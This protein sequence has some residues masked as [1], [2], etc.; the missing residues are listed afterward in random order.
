MPSAAAAAPVTTP[1]ARR[2][3][4]GTSTRTPRS[5]TETPSGRRYVNTVWTGS[6]SATLTRQRGMRPY[7]IVRGSPARSA[8]Q[9]RQHGFHVFPDVLL[10]GRIAQQIG[11][12]I[13][14]NDLDAFVL[15]QAA[16]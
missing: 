2:P 16:A 9:D 6:G 13:R 10:C 8:V 5:G 1:I 7:S 4:N 15:S 14:R 3:A 12:V 11:R